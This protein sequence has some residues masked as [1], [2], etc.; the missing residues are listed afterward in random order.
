M[1]V[2]RKNLPLLCCAKETKVY[3]AV[4]LRLI[5]TILFPI[6]V[7]VPDITVGSRRSLRKEGDVPCSGR[8]SG[9]RGLTYTYRDRTL[10]G[11]LKRTPSSMPHHSD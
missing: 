11:S 8:R 5:C 1:A 4:P 2:K 3:S 7:Y 10:S 6:Q 9:E